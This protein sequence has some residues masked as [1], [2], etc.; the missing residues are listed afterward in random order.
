M[1]RRL[2]LRVRVNESEQEAYEREAAQQG[3]SIS[4]WVRYVIAEWIER[5][6]RGAA[7]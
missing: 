1:T 2:E 4:A 3:L 6:R 7:E 5:H